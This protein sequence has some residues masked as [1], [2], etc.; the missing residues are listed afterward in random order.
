[1]G[2]YPENLSIRPTFVA[3][4]LA[5]DWSY[6]FHIFQSGVCERLASFQWE[7]LSLLLQSK[8]VVELLLHCQAAFRAKLA[9][10]ESKEENR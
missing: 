2:L 6:F 10:I 4:G 8:D 3:L 9:T 5:P 1:M 7:M